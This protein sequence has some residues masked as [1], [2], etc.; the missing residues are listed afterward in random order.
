MH[1]FI[2]ELQHFLF[3]NLKTED[4]NMSKYNEN[5]VKK[6]IYIFIQIKINTCLFYTTIQ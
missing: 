5:N 6:T 2:Y 3:D 4:L 1:L